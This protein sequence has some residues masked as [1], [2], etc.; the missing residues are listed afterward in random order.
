MSGE[1]RNGKE[2]GREKYNRTRNQNEKLTAV[3]NRHPK[4]QRYCAK[5]GRKS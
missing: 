1:S 4:F 5:K 3:W 2:H